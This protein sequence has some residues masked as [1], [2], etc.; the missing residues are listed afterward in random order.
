MF[1]RR[2]IIEEITAHLKKDEITLI[3][4]ARQTGKTTILKQ[5]EKEHQGFFLNLENL[6]F[7]KLLNES[8]ENI[9]TIFPLKKKN[10]TKQFLFID[11]VQYL[12]NP[13]NFLKYVYDE[14][15]HSIK[16][17]VTGS[18]AFYVDKKFKDSLAGRKKIFNLFSLNIRDFFLF[19]ERPDLLEYVPRAFSPDTFSLY[20]NPPVSLQKDIEH[21][22]EEF[23]LYGGYPRVAL[24]PDV[25]EKR[26]I[27]EELATSYIKKDILEADIK[28]GEKYYDL[29]KLLSSQIGGQVN[30]NELSN[31]LNI[32]RPT[33]EHYLYV[34][35]KSF[36]FAL[37][38]PFGGSVR[39]EIRKMPKGY[40]YDTGLRNYFIN[41]FNTLAMRQDPGQL[42]E[43]FLFKQLLD[44]V[45]LRDI[46]YWRTVSGEEVDFVVQERIAFEAKFRDAG[47]TRSKYSS[48]LKIYTHI[49]L[50][51]ISYIV[52]EKKASTWHVWAI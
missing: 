37:I 30:A 49:P 43:N 50:H 39:K 9:F 28:E 31:T 4:G 16:L 22:F 5:L 46:Q 23:M 27:L 17:V 32:S 26:E 29:F 44:K 21:L 40:F 18:S 45:R 7:L 38:R 52:S 14:Y 15:A 12:D 8:P 47:F 1:Y 13:T 6:E 20:E 24:A 3:T 48:F 51:V 2:E 36:H 42:F 11:E 33:V 34:M 25:N 10:N 35:Q 19:K 41:N